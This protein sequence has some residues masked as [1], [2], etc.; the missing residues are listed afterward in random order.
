MEKIICDIRISIKLLYN[1]DLTLY[2]AYDN[3]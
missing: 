3:I 2:L 1:K